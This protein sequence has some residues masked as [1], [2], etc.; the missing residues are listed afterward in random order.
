[1]SVN[2][3]DERGTEMEILQFYFGMVSVGSKEC[4]V[5][6][7]AQR[8]SEAG[9]HTGLC[10]T[11]LSFVWFY[12]LYYWGKLLVAPGFPAVE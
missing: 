2:C 10:D 6:T 4:P 11:K 12:M 1:M 7:V 8:M 3:R 9:V 5:C